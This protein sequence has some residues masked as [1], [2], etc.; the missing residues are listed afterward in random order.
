MPSRRTDTKHD[1]RCVCSRKPLLALYGVNDGSV[2][3][4]IKIYKQGRIFG[5]VIVTE[6]KMKIRC[7]ECLRWLNLVVSGRTADL[8]P[9][10]SEP[11]ELTEGTGW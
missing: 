10:Q 3:V 8:L 4:W 9:I 5:E 7:R 6:G 2:Y 11:E 1:L